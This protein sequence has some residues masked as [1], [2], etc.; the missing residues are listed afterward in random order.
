MVVDGR[1]REERR[2]I[3]IDLCARCTLIITLTALTKYT[4]ISVWSIG[5]K[6]YKIKGNAEKRLRNRKPGAALWEGGARGRGPSL[7]HK[8][9][10]LYNVKITLYIILC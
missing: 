6:M 2:F 8:N 1:V 9:I 10:K 7:T 4:I 3:K 5:I